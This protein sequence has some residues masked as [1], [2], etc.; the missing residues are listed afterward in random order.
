M[1]AVATPAAAMGISAASTNRVLLC[2]I[3]KLRFPARVPV[4][5]AMTLMLVFAVPKSATA[6]VALVV[7][8]LRVVVEVALPVLAVTVPATVNVPVPALAVTVPD[9]GSGV[10]VTTTFPPPPPAPTRVPSGL[11]TD[12]TIPPAGMSVP[13]RQKYGHGIERVVGCVGRTHLAGDGLVAIQ[14]NP[15]GSRYG[16]RNRLSH[17]VR[18]PRD[19]DDEVP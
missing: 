7:T 12:T 6:P 14:L 19:G 5:W 17:E 4:L 8:A 13:F 16:S 2:E 9:T 15:A 3:L 18:K 10:L 11:S 1:T